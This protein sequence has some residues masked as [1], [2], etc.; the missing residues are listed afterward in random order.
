MELLTDAIVMGESPRWH[1]G[2]LFVADWG[3]GT[4]V[5]VDAGGRTEPAAPITGAACF[6]FLPDGRWLVVAEDRLLVG[7]PF[8]PL[9]PY[10]DLSPAGSYFNDIVVD[11]R[12]NAYVGA[13]GFDF[14]GGAPPAAGTLALVRASGE[15]VQVADDVHFPNGVA[16]TADNG[17][18]VLAE[19][20]GNR[21]SAWDIAADGTLSGR[22]SWA[23]LGT[24]VP[25]GICVDATGAVWYADVP[26]RCCVRVADG[27]A[28]LDTVTLDRGAF[29]CMLGGSTLYVVAN[30][31]G[32]VDNT[33]GGRVYAVPAP[34]PGAGWPS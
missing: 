8:G 21:L 25:D 12:G 31:W 19:S 9:E 10:A 34:A 7:E 24:G 20:Y 17:T 11:G 32:G 22:R 23:E 29:A 4:I 14:G 18:L 3:A 1:D 2:R 15:V 5:A 6:D 28:V 33:S 26:N 30:E 13:L 27:G 16:V